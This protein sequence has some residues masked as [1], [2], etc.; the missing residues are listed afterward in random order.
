MGGFSYSTTLPCEPTT[1]EEQV[2]E[3]PPVPVDKIIGLSSEQNSVTFF[4][5][6]ADCYPLHESAY[7]ERDS[8]T[9]YKPFPKALPFL[10]E[11]IFKVLI[12]QSYDKHLP[13]LSI[14]SLCAYLTESELSAYEIIIK[15]GEAYYKQTN[16]ILAQGSYRFI[17]QN[18][19]I[20]AVK[21]FNNPILFHSYLS[22]GKP[23][24]AAGI[25]EVS[26]PGHLY[27]ISNE[28]GHYRINKSDF[29]DFLGYML[30]QLKNPQFQFEDYSEKGKITRYYAW[31][32]VAEHKKINIIW[33]GI[34]TIEEK[35]KDWSAS[36]KEQ[37]QTPAVKKAMSLLIYRLNPLF[38]FH[39]PR[40]NSTLS[41]STETSAP[42]IRRTKSLE[43]PSKN[44]YSTSI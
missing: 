21:G 16:K 42:P 11:L 10:R 23:V 18:D 29:M 38:Q 40:S 20:Y 1:N 14:I 2:K 12:K 37:S 36:S 6:P 28:S 30:Q 13:T 9:D 22:Q 17:A 7:E 3:L 39:L 24:A 34:A 19:K 35:D 4:P 5:F 26:R 43:T 44:S 8:Q 15:D 32:L 41:I 25:F 33:N 31:P 27:L